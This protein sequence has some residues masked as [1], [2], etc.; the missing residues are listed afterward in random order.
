MYREFYVEQ[1]LHGYSNG[2]R[3]LQTSLELSEQD[4][5]KMLI[6][7]DISGNEFYDGFES[8]FTGYRL[9]DSRIVLACTWYAS[10]MKR[11]GCVWTHSLIINTR[12]LFSCAKYLD[13]IIKIFKKPN[14]NSGLESYSHTLKIE[15][16]NESPLDGE[17]LKYLIWCLWGN[18]NPLVVFENS[19]KDLEK[20]LIYLFLSQH[21]LLEPTFSFC[22]G[23]FAL[24]EY[25]GNVLNL[26]VAPNKV[27][28]SKLCIG[29]RAYEAK[30][31][32]LIKNYPLWVNKIYDNLSKDGMEEFRNFI[33]GFSDEYKKSKYISA[34]IKL[35]VG[36]NADTHDANLIRL[37]EMAFAI[38]DAKEEIFNQIIE[39]YSH[40]YFEKWR[41]KENIIKTLLFFIDNSG[42][43]SSVLDLETLV[44]EA[45]FSEF[46]DSKLLFK[47]LVKKDESLLTER[48]LKCYSNIITVEQLS[49][50]TDLEYESCSTLI[51]IRNEFAMCQ[52]IWKLSQRYQQGIIRCFRKKQVELDHKIIETVLRNS[53]YDMAHDLFKA[54]G[55]ECIQ[56]FWKYLLHNRESNKTKGIID[57]V[58]KDTESG[59][60][61]ILCNMKERETLLFLLGIVDSYN[62]TIKK[63][64]QEDIVHIYQSVMTEGCL[65][66]EKETLARF[67]VPICIIQ[68]YMVDVEIAKFT[69]KIINHMLETQTFPEN[70]WDKLEKIL[71]EVAYYNNWDRC[72]RLRKGFKKKGYSFLKKNHK[73][74]LPLHLL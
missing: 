15:N 2:H 25:N 8:Y 66:K 34:F 54:Y 38:F 61:Q 6:L 11:P 60:N 4:S 57:I 69:F 47:I 26:Q 45:Y 70:E 24:R 64:H 46:D 13:D 27:S 33:D 23:S 43:D 56:P 72:K 12:D 7:S 37:L 36:S 62:K 3:L 19:S 40:K 1:T 74:D 9:S 35:Y 14:L 52:D 17:K 59:I 48:L 30:D 73:K 10:E 71:P 67:L 29:K 58:R 5:K 65:D 53:N 22:T 51:S 49:T 44:R 42:L 32:A 16:C 21:D 39:L 68:D 20:E 50:F 31:R 18:S 41:G 63:L 28:R 55:D